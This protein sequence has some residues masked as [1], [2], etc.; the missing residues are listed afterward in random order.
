MKIKHHQ[1]AENS[2]ENQENIGC[3]EQ[4]NEIKGY[5][6]GVNNKNNYLLFSE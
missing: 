5:I 3:E 6:K 1:L 4:E 2:T